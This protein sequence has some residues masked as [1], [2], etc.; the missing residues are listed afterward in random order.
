[1]PAI[2][3][4][5][6]CDVCAVMCDLHPLLP[7][8][9]PEEQ[10]DGVAGTG[11]NANGNAADDGDAGDASGGATAAAGTGEGGGGGGSGG[12]GGGG[13][14][15]ATESGN[16]ARLPALPA[17]VPAWSAGAR[18]V[19]T[20]TMLVLVRG[21]TFCASHAAANEDV[22][23]AGQVMAWALH[24]YALEQLDARVLL[25]T[26]ACCAMLPDHQRSA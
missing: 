6:F 16:A 2:S 20:A 9:P 5:Q 11:D 12:G 4:L 8:P 18:A 22:R 25:A 21:V 13:S 23:R 14:G 19:D 17:A 26:T 10:G 15:K 7:S 24:A 1:M 3:Q